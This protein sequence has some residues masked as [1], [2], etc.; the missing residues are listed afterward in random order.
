[1]PVYNIEK[2][3]RESLD[4]I[5]SQSF[6]KFECICVDDGSSDSSLQILHAYA[7]LD[8]RIRVIHQNNK[9]AGNAR[10]VGMENAK[11]EYI[12]FLDGD[13]LFERDLLQC[14]V[15]Q[16]EKY[17]ADI[18]AFGFNAFDDDG[19]VHER[20]SFHI[21]WLKE[22]KPVFNYKDCPNSIMSIIN[23]TPWNKIYSSAFLR[24]TRVRFEEITSSNDITF[25]AVSVAMAERIAVIDNVLLHYRIG[26]DGTITKT[27]STKLDNSVRAI[28][29]AEEQVRKLPYFDDIRNSV[30][31]FVIGNYIFTWTHYVVDK[32]EKRAELFFNHMKERMLSYG[33][34][35]SRDC[36]VNDLTYLH[37]KAII[38]CDH[39]QYVSFLD[40]KKV[41]SL[42]SYPERIMYVSKALES[43]LN[44][45][46]SL[47]MI[48]LWLYRDDFPNKEKDLPDELVEMSSD[49]R[50]VIK[51]CD[52]DLRP[53]KKY[54]Y[55]FMEYPDAVI[56]TFDDDLVYRPDLVEKLVYS[57]MCYP[58]AV[59]AARAHFMTIEKE[60]KFQPYNE[61]IKDIQNYEHPSYR[62][63]ATGGAGCLYPIGEYRYSFLKE[64]EIKE[65]ALCQDDL[66]MKAIELV[67]NIEVVL[68]GQYTGLMYVEGSQ[69]SALFTNNKVN[70]NDIAWNM[71]Q[72][73][74]DNLYGENTLLNKVLNS[75]SQ[76]MIELVCGQYKHIISEYNLNEKTLRQM[77]NEK[78]S[79][80]SHLEKSYSYRLGLMLTALPRKIVHLIKR[81]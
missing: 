62:L 26:H 81:D 14:A 51:Y 39:E 21:E 46:F 2:Y 1:M 40:E 15:K 27:K 13:D 43:L 77:L 65:L 69:D 5:L 36:F 38:A 31:R 49:E 73:Y 70:G 4:S 6:R 55:S 75:S 64:K 56:V 59:S 22:K 35:I 48:V 53:H 74:I 52:T 11:G 72:E 57:H 42:T 50:I 25:A 28:D 47:D 67:E 80:I 44:Q 12:V 71:L 54:Y 8:E 60:K 23:P 19:N 78:E 10:N 41:G 33:A 3:L 79:R 18:V 32:H 37:Y 7:R 16:I 17:Q 61:W 30:I 24:K 63:F 66:W 9:G 34:D 68:A 29:S 76:G 58:N 45:S 20:K